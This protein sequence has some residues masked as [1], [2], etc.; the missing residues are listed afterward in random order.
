MEIIYFEQGFEPR[1]CPGPSVLAG[2]TAVSF[3]WKTSLY[4]CLLWL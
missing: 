3:T 2:R 1:T 4:H